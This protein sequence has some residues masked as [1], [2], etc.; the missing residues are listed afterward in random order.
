MIRFWA[1]RLWG[2]NPIVRRVDRVEALV[3]G[4]A[5]IAAVIALPACVWLG[6]RL[7]R[8]HQNIHA[9]SRPPHTVAAV[10]LTKS[11]A[12]PG[13]FA[14]IASVQARWVAD[15]TVRVAVVRVD[16]PLAAGD[17]FDMW[18]DAGGAPTN[19]PGSPSRAAMEATSLAGGAWMFAAAASA[20]LSVAASR[21]AA[22]RRDAAWDRALVTLVA[23]DD[24][25]ANRQ[26]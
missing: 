9:D 23:D 16:R 12:Q 20:G 19:A 4:L 7:L 13:K 17:R 6:G 3:I 1:R 8:D 21:V 22:H 10:A 15:S 26:P 24:G 11:T 5:V 18:V 25:R 2:A 14:N